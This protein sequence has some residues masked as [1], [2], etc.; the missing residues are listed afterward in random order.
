[1]EIFQEVYI[2]LLTVSNQ[3]IGISSKNKNTLIGK[4]LKNKDFL[5]D[6]F[7]L[8]GYYVKPTEEELRVRGTSTTSSMFLQNSFK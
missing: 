2:R 4:I 7:C 1:M 6:I 3:T 8:D 5:L